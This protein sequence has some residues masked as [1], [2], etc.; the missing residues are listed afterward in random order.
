MPLGDYVLRTRIVQENVGWFGQVGKQSIRVGTLAATYAAPI[1]H[2]WRSGET[3]TVNVTV[4]NTGTLIWTATGPTPVNLAA[5]F[6]AASD[7]AGAWTS[8]PVRFALPHDVAPGASVIVPILITAP[9]APGD[10]VLRIRLVKE[11]MAWFGQ[12]LNQPIYV[13]TLAAAYSSSAPCFGAA[14]KPRP[15]RSRSRTPARFR[16]PPPAQIPSA[17]G[18]I[19]TL[20]MTM[21]DPGPASPFASTWQALSHPAAARR[22]K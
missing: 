4:V 13:G 12:V 16:G 19:L 20:P 17:W 18:S 14:A 1:P 22:S 3:Q 9:L 2:L 11:N 21:S 6:D 15:S 5:Y 8:E 7:I 10:H